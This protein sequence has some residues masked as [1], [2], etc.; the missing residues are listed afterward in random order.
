MN[1]DSRGVVVTVVP[2]VVVC[3]VPVV[4]VSGVVVAVVVDVVSAGV[5]VV[6]VSVTR[7]ATVYDNIVA[8]LL[9]LTL[10]LFSNQNRQNSCRCEAF[11]HTF[12]FT[13]KS[14]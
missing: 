7:A 1:C 5:V 6:V 2:V 9:K 4:V 11:F 3:V 8:C 14:N 10:N 12:L 13:I